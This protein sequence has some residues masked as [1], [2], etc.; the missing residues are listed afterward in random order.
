MSIK[1][2]DKLLVSK[3][4]SGTVIDHINSGRALVVLKILN[5]K[6]NEGYRIAIVMNVP[7]TT[8][9]KKDIVKLEDYYPNSEDLEKI[10]LISPSAT[11][12]I[13]KNY[14]VVKKYKVE[15]PSKIKGTLKCNNPTC[16]TRKSN[17]PITSSFTLL[18]KDK[19]KL[20]CDYCGSI[21]TEDDIIKELIGESQ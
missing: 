6:G 10:S 8:M 11:I 13:I 17:E 19:I 7:S 16:I 12:N 5:I 2:D 9:G 3:I 20:Q 14:E 18:S 1:K 21:L 15:I 4:E